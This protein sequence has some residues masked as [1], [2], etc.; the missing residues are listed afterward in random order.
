M[1]EE[2]VRR[3]F[4]CRHGKTEANEKR[5]YCGGMNE[6][7]LSE[8]GKKQAILLGKALKNYYGFQGKFIISSARE[9]ARKTSEIISQAFNPSP[10]ILV[11]ES[12]REIDGGEW[13]GKTQKEVQKLYPKECKEWYNGFLKPNFRFPGGESMKEARNRVKYCFEI[14][15]KIWLGNEDE[16][17]NDL[18]IVAHS[19]V[20]VIILTDIMASEMK[21]YGFRIFRQD[22]ACVNII[23][24]HEKTSWRPEIEIILINSTH[25]LSSMAE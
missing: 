18:I 6:T 7:P 20:N 15:K 16:K 23:G 24:F 11:A 22:N 14:V 5:L 13:E 4:L 12:L 19:G 2:K 10:F 17:N 8:I 25:H 3:L 1:A 9:R 21:T